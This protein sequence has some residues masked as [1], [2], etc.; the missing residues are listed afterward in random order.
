MEH[1]Y[2]FHIGKMLYLMNCCKKI[3][4]DK[5]L[6]CFLILLIIII[7]IIVV[8]LI[9]RISTFFGIWITIN[10]ADITEELFN[11]D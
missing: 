6:I 2:C 5:I 8:I 11:L 3:V 10:Q 4:F 7:I 9:P 1:L